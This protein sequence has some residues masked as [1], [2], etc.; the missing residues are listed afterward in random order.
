[1]VIN[2]NRVTC[3]KVEKDEKPAV[4][5]HTQAMDEKS[6]ISDKHRFII[7]RWLFFSS[8]LHIIVA[9]LSLLFGIHRAAISANLSSYFQ[10]RGR[11]EILSGKHKSLKDFLLSYTI[12]F[13]V[14]TVFAGYGVY[15]LW[16]SSFCCEFASC[17]SY[18]KCQD[19]IGFLRAMGTTLLIGH[20]VFEACLLYVFRKVYEYDEMIENLKKDD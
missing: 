8:I 2:G 16:S 5:D 18:Q 15:V 1:M 12:F 6:K 11:S 10:I 20:V 9:T 17:I 4:Y 13:V 7:R 19:N 14:N 3:V